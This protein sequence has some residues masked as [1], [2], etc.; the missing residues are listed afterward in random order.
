MRR[1]SP[2]AWIGIGGSSS[3]FFGTGIAIATIDASLVPFTGMLTELLAQTFEYR[4][5]SDG[6]AVVLDHKGCLERI[7][8]GRTL[9]EDWEERNRSNRTLLASWEYFFLHFAGLSFP[10][11]RPSLTEAQ[12]FI[13]FQLTSAMEVFVT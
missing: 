9:L 7:K 3:D 12:H 5:T 10:W 4:E 6:V 13:R 2:S 11:P 1:V 8:G